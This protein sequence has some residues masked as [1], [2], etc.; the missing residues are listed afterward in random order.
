MNSNEIFLA[1]AI[2]AIDEVLASGG[3]FRIY[4][5]GKSMLPLIVE[6]RDSVVLSREKDVPLKKYD[7]AF[8]RRRDGHF[9]L[10]R[11]MRVE[12]DGTYTM[13]G[14][15]Q[16][17][18]ERGI[19]PAHIIARVCEITRNGKSIKLDGF[20]YSAYV[21]FWSVKPIRWMAFFPRRAIGKI[22]RIFR[23]LFAKD[24]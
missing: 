19:T 15:N 6:E 18:Y 8:Y 10:H 24:A 14:D 1:D 12:N 20:F 4:P 5:R 7:I 21:F 11:V 3:T 13:C 9:V 2:E 17:V 22:K 23:R 16:L